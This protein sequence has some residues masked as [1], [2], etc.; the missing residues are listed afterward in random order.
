MAGQGMNEIADELLRRSRDGRLAW[1]QTRKGNEY[2]VSF[3]DVSLA[4][5]HEPT[6]NTYQ[7]D[8]IN[9]AGSVIESIEWSPFYS[10]NEKQEDKDFRRDIL[11]DIYG[12]A[13]MYVQEE[14]AQRALQYLK[15][16]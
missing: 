14:V 6:L 15:Q 11:Q 10:P 1:K 9:E 7:L 13:E 8:L 16:S 3:P 12:F 5:S 4:I 2:R